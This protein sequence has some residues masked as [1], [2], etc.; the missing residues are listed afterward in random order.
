MNLQY[1]LPSK[2]FENL[3][4][5]QKDAINL[6]IETDGRV[7][8]ADEMGLGKTLEALC[9]AYIFRHDWP[10]LVLCPAS[11][12]SQWSDHILKW[13]FP[14]IEKTDIFLWFNRFP[15]CHEINKFSIVIASYDS[16]KTLPKPFKTFICD[17]C[18]YLKNIKTKRFKDVSILLNNC[19]HLIMLSGTPLSSNNLTDLYAQYTLFPIHIDVPCDQK[20]HNLCQ[21]FKKE[22]LKD[23]LTQKTRHFLSVSLTKTNENELAQYMRE[24]P[25]ASWENIC[26]QMKCMSIL[27]Q[28]SEWFNKLNNKV[29]LFYKHREVKN[30]FTAFFP[31][32]CVVIDG[33]VDKSDRKNLLDYFE[34]SIKNK[35]LLLQIKV[36]NAGLDLSQYLSIIFLELDWNP[37]TL[38]Q[39]ED[40]IYR[41]GQ[42]SDVN[43]F[44]F[45]CDSKVHIDCQKFIPRLKLKLEYIADKTYIKDEHMIF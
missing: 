43:I 1:L 2:V 19:K 24:I 10:L 12:I 28:Y 15:A 42:T 36:G 37:T 16:V 32:T 4:P 29:I 44:Y 11:L 45:I 20:P 27:N 13:F 7:Y 8:I 34:K 26:G 41:L 18:Q 39:A 33:K 25:H 38:L 31:N 30:I 23:S 22:Q 21:R 40:R 35:Y 6:G 5:Y 9:I 17:E 3:K 14:C